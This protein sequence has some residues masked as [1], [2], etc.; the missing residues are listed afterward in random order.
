MAKRI[1]VIF[2]YLTLR[3]NNGLR[4][5][6]PQ[7]ILPLVEMDIPQHWSVSYCKINKYLDHK[8]YIIGGWLGQGPLAADDMHILDL[9]KNHWVDFQ[10]K[11]IPPGP[12]NM[13]TADCYK[14]KIYVFRG[15]DGKDYLND[16]HELD[17]QA[18]I[19]T[20]PKADGTCPPPRA[21]HSSSL[22]K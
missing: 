7:E 21:N 14:N 22:I 9:A 20:R 18:L 19:W 8:L 11:G 17:T 13:H 5:R 4:L 10:W 1:I 15:G 16:L 3:L 12:C 6:D 2:E